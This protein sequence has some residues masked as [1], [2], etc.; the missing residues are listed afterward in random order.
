M[1]SINA[2]ISVAAITPLGNAGLL[3]LPSRIPQNEPTQKCNIKNL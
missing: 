1:S 2:I 3:L